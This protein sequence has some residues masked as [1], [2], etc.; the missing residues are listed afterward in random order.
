[1]SPRLRL[2]PL[3]LA[4]LLLAAC[5]RHDRPGDEEQVLHQG[6]G[7]DPND[8]DPQ[9]V[10]S[11]QAAAIS[12]AL[13]EGLTNYDPADL[14]P[15]P[16]VAESWDVSADGL[17]Y[18]FHLRAN[19]RWSNGEPVTAEDF[20][21]SARRLLSPAFA[22]EFAYMMFPIR[23]A[24]DFATGRTRDF[25]QVGVRAPDARTLRYELHRPA[26]YFLTL[27]AHWC[28]YPVPAATLLRHGRIDQPGTAWTRPENF[29]GN[30]AFALKSWRQGEGVV[31]APNPWY[32][33]APRVRL[34]G[35]HFHFID[36]PDTEER[37]FRNGQLQITSSMPPGRLGAYR[38][39][40]GGVLRATPAFETD[41]LYLNL[42]RRPLD[43]V[44]VRRALSLAIDRD[45]LT[46]A[47]LRDGSVPAASLVPDDPHGYAYR[48]EP[49]LRFD[50]A[51]ARR[52][53][54]A[55]GFPAGRGFPPLEL[56]FPNG[57]LAG[58]LC[59]ALQQMWR[60]HLGVDVGLVGQERR[61]FIDN[62]HA[63]RFT[64]SLSGWIGDYLDPMSFLDVYLSASGHNDPGYRNPEFDQLLE[65]AAGTAG[66]ELRYERFQQAEAMLLR[67]LP[68]LPLNHRPNLHLVAPSVHGYAD[69]LM[70]M[71]PYPA[72]WLE[73]K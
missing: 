60:R 39:T 34:R 55:A 51:E 15:V 40:P 25:G 63:H 28:W 9:I 44:R 41:V 7:A 38:G 27:T 14:H 45:A 36:N 52:L 13:G 26:P 17:A 73:S 3:A 68:S 72:I 53:L 47:V 10:S 64:L 70:D 29:V 4:F 12:M 50:P 65:Q 49:R 62:V 61:V 69:N 54:A 43:D 21:F 2:P 6:V 59:E 48:G 66:R 16:G 33:D 20:V 19:A 1:V 5:G 30:G 57:G 31:V 37:A 18:T 56:S 8:L 32:W 11:N 46:S 35:I 67:D 22:G 58:P 71:H 23:G 24:E 42:G